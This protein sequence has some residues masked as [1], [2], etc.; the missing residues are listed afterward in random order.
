MT[1]KK[2]WRRKRIE[3]DSLSAPQVIAYLEGALEAN[4]ARGKV[5][6]PDDYLKAD[7]SEKYESRVRSEVSRIVDEIASTERIKRIVTRL[8]RK[9]YELGDARQ[10]IG[11]GFEEDDKLNWETPVKRRLS[12]RSVELESELQQVVMKVFMKMLSEQEGSP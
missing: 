6:P 4:G 11:K 10:W 1:R 8:F 12:Q 9:R 3:L 7:V 5:I 2:A